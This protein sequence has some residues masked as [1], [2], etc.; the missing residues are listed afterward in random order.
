[1]QEKCPLPAATFLFLKIVIL[2]SVES[3]RRTSVEPTLPWRQNSFS[4]SKRS[5]LLEIVSKQCQDSRG[6]PKGGG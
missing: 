6:F 3:M 4:I 5:S 2:K 1:M